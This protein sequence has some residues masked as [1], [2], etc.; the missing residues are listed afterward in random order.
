LSPAT[1]QSQSRETDLPA[2]FSVKAGQR[3][4]NSGDIILVSSIF[5]AVRVRFPLGVQGGEECGGRKVD[6]GR[7]RTE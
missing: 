2:L 4:G 1:A 5:K 7:D 3:N 6:K